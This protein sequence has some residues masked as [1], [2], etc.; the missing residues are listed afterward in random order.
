MKLSPHQR[1]SCFRCEYINVRSTRLAKSELDDVPLFRQIALRAAKI[2]FRSANI[3]QPFPCFQCIGI[4]RIAN[5]AVD[6][7]GV[8]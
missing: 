5:I 2:A 1:V 7:D 4:C 6:F 3:G 8:G